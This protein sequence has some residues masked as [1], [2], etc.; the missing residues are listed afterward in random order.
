MSSK[1]LLIRL[2]SARLSLIF[3]MASMSYLPA[4]AV[5]G[6]VANSDR[7]TDSPVLKRILANW[8][9]RQER[10]KSV[11]IS[12]KSKVTKEPSG[13]IGL[14]GGMGGGMWI[15]DKHPGIETSQS[16][17][18]IRGNECFRYE[19]PESGGRSLVR[20]FDGRSDRS[21]FVGGKPLDEGRGVE[22]DVDAMRS[23]DAF[24]LAPLFLSFRPMHAAL[25]DGRSQRCRLVTEHAIL[26]GIHCSKIECSDPK[27]RVVDTCWVDPKRKDVIVEWQR[28]TSGYNTAT[29]SIDYMPHPIHGYLPLRWKVRSFPTRTESATVAD[30]RI[31]L[32]VPPNTFVANIP[33]QSVVSD[34]IANVQYYVRENGSKRMI[35]KAE[36][37]NGMRYFDLKREDRPILRPTD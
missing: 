1:V 29:I 20:I 28:S 25:S 22:R 27:N 23:S 32:V 5:D 35:T 31:N 34:H 14:L 6:D 3:T 16:D 9:S 17:L 18:W 37:D 36:L 10:F 13:D 12:W 21:C 33:T 15:G 24:Q 7:V 30:C 8:K 19:C 11:R 4:R 26:D 2:V